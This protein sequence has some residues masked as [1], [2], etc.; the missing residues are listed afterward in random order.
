MASSSWTLGFAVTIAVLAVLVHQLGMFDRPP[1]HDAPLPNLFAV[2]GT[3]QDANFGQHIPRLLNTTLL[4]VTDELANGKERLVMAAKSYNNVP[5]TTKRLSVGLYIDNPHDTPNPRWAIG[6]ALQAESLEA[7]QKEVAAATV[8]KKKKVEEKECG[9]L[10]AVQVPAGDGY[11]Q[12]RI[13]WRTFLT[14][15]IAP[16][17]HWGRGFAD[18][19]GGHD[20]AIAMEVYVTSHHDDG[21]DEQEKFEYI[22]YVVLAEVEVNKRIIKDAFPTVQEES[23]QEDTTSWEKQTP[24]EEIIMNE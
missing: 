11:R 2:V 23:Q 21:E 5:A 20:T 22:D 10:R 18:I 1:F 8:E 16:L 14:P 7:L 13:P 4:F 24:A 9:A 6:W 3:C 15:M 12:A 17:L 19:K